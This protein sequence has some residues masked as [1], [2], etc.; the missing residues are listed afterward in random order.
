MGQ[1]SLLQ[2][3]RVQLFAIFTKG[4][5]SFTQRLMQNF[6]LGNITQTVTV[7]AH[8]EKRLGDT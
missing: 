2:Y 1:K 8:L 6:Q 4:K 5:M 7:H 3:R